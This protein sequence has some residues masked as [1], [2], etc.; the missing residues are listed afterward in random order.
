MK[1]AIC[2]REVV[3]YNYKDYYD[4]FCTCGLRLRGSTRKQVEGLWERMNNGLLD[5]EIIEII[6]CVLNNIQE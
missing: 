4:I 5:N 1:C 3:G 6:E 2:G